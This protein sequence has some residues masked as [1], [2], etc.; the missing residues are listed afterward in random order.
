MLESYQRLKSIK[1]N[2]D[3]ETVK[4]IET[5]RSLK[6]PV[7]KN[8]S[9]EGIYIKFLEDPFFRAKLEI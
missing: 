9:E 6:L 8:L 5:F 7:L 4:K 3:E 2:I 1:E